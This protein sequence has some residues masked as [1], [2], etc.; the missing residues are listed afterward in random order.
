MTQHLWDIPKVANIFTPTDEQLYQSMHITRDQ[1]LEIR[2]TISRTIQLDAF[3]RIGIF[4]Q[5]QQNNILRSVDSAYVNES[6]GHA[7]RRE[8]EQQLLPWIRAM[9]AAIQLR[10]SSKYA[11]RKENSDPYPKEKAINY[12]IFNELSDQSS[13]DEILH[14]I[15]ITVVNKHQETTDLIFSQEQLDEYITENFFLTNSNSSPTTIISR[16]PDSD[17]TCLKWTRFRNGNCS[18]W[19]SPK[20]LTKHMV[21]NDGRPRPN[22]TSS[23]GDIHH[24]FRFISSN[25]TLSTQCATRL[26][27]ALE[28]SFQSNQLSQLVDQFLRAR[29][30]AILP[31]DLQ[32]IKDKLALSDFDQLLHYL[33]SNQ[34]AFSI[35]HN[36]V[37][38]IS[39]KTF[40]NTRGQNSK[41]HQ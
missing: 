24:S 36:I 29:S 39:H 6:I 32:D 20:L 14:D 7:I 34:R 13:E 1:L 17:T 9:S 25:D 15:R 21:D 4:N 16:I 35:I 27:L 10:N 33:N 12:N 3:T 31:D 18:M 41:K 22:V 30:G 37:N 11:T 26:I 5:E 38:T 23:Q 2:N 19:I 40:M 28:T 8:I